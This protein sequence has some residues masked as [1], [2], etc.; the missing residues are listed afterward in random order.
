MNRAMHYIE[1]NL[2]E[3]I[4]FQK[5][6]QL[7]G[8]SEYHFMRMFAF[9]SGFTLSEYIRR[10]KLTLAAAELQSSPLRIIDIAVKYGYDSPDAFT[11]AFQKLH[12]VTPSEARAAGARL[13]AVSPMTFQ[14]TIR[15]GSEMEYRIVEKEAFQIVGLKKRVALIYEGV[16]P[17][18]AALWQSLTE[19]DIRELKQLSNL[20]P[21]G[22]ISASVNFEDG[23]SEG[24][25]LDQYIGVAT[26][27][28]AAPRWEVLN[29]SAGA[30]AVFTA[31][32]K[33]PAALQNVW[34]RIYA[35]WAPSSGYELRPG[36]EILWNESKD[37]TL[38]Q[39]RSEIW[40]PV[41]K[42]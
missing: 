35:E 19:K 22:L 17:E 9:L 24:S 3:S 11:R 13:K 14:L 21:G 26:N 33:F 30:W 8:C 39:Y 15:G 34:G 2:L 1:A 42:P 10:R 32:G 23:R 40:I 12:G 29:V 31:V 27:L 7:A 16:N 4:D 18:I 20:E 36:P 41:V 37:T 5:V 25:F 6:A 28:P 38:P